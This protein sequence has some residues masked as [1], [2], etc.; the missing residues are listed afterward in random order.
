MRGKTHCAIGVLSV[1]QASILFKIH[2]SLFNLIISALFAILPDLDEANST[3]SNLLLKKDFSKSVLKCCV[4]LINILLFFISLK[5][6]DNFFISALITFVTIIIIESKLNHNT[7]RKLF[8]S[9][10][11]ILLAFCLYLISKQISFV[12]FCLML[13]IFPWLK[14]RGYSHSLFAIIIIHFLL[15]QIELITN[16]SN[17][18]FFGTVS[19]ASHIFLGDLFTRSGIPIFY[20]ISEKKYS[21]C[22]FKVGV[23]FS[24]I[25]EMLFILFLLSMIIY[26]I[27]KI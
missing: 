15:K 27:I 16:I 11:F 24:N 9:L 13:A 23:F 19:Y 22:F 7:L 18:C 5:I 10:V 17:L 1:I 6:N 26:S 20:P 21:L 3:I 14:H 4:Y 12:I 2:I 25:L 8:L